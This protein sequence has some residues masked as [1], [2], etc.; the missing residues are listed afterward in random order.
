MSRMEEAY[1]RPQNP[2]IPVMVD[3]E[4]ELPDD[5]PVADDFYEFAAHPLESSHPP[6]PPRGRRSNSHPE[7]P[8]RHGTDPAAASTSANA[9]P[10]EI[11]GTPQRHGGRVPNEPSD[12]RSRNF[13]SFWDLNLLVARPDRY[14][15]QDIGVV[16]TKWQ[17]AFQQAGNGAWD[18]VEY[19][20]AWTDPDWDSRFLYIQG[21]V[22]EDALTVQYAKPGLFQTQ[23]PALLPADAQYGPSDAAKRWGFFPWQAKEQGNDV[24]DGHSGVTPTLTNLPLDTS[25]RME[26]RISVTAQEFQRELLDYEKTAGV[27]ATTQGFRQALM[28]KIHQLS[29]H[30]GNEAQV[31]YAR[32]LLTFMGSARE[33][34]NDYQR[35]LFGGSTTNELVERAAWTLDADASTDLALPLHDLVKRERWATASESGRGTLENR[36]RIVYNV[37]NKQGEY[38][39][40]DETLW[41]AMQPALQLVSKVLSMNH[42]MTWAWADIRKTQPT[43]SALDEM[44]DERDQV[45]DEDKS[46]GIKRKNLFALWPEFSGKEEDLD[47]ISRSFEEMRKFCQLGFDSTRYACEILKRTI[48]WEIDSS[49]RVAVGETGDAAVE[50]LKRSY[51]ASHIE[52]TKDQDPPF[53]IQI[54]ISANFLWPLLVDEY[55]AAEK[56]ATSFLVASTMLHE[57]AHAL[58]FARLQMC[59]PAVPPANVPLWQQLDPSWPQ[60]IL[61]Y[62]NLHKTDIQHWLELHGRRWRTE[63]SAPEK[64]FL[65]HLDEAFVEN[66]PTAEEGFATEWEYWGGILQNPSNNSSD[67]GLWRFL[68]EVYSMLGLKSWASSNAVSNRK[69]LSGVLSM[70]QYTRLYKTA[71]WDHQAMCFGHD[72]IKVTSEAL[73]ALIYAT[74]FRWQQARTHFGAPAAA[75][76]EQA[77][78][79]VKDDSECQLLWRWLYHRTVDGV[80]A[81]AVFG[82]WEAWRSWWEG[83]DRLAWA[84]SAATSTMFETMVT[85][86]DAARARRMSGSLADFYPDVEI[87]GFFTAAGHALRYFNVEAMHAQNLAAIYLRLRESPHKQAVWDLHHEKMQARMDEFYL[88]VIA[89]IIAQLEYFSDNNTPQKQNDLQWLT[90]H[91]GIAPLI[92]TLK[93]NLE[94]KLQIAFTFFKQVRDVFTYAQPQQRQQQH[95]EF[96]HGLASLPSSA[97][98][99]A[100]ERLRRMG[101]AEY[102]RLA[103]DDV[104]KAVADSWAAIIVGEDRLRNPRPGTVEA[105]DNLVLREVVETVAQHADTQRRAMEARFP[106]PPNQGRQTPGTGLVHQPTPPANRYASPQAFEPEEAQLFRRITG[107][108]RVQDPKTGFTHY[109]T[110]QDQPTNVEWWEERASS[111][112][113]APPSA[114]S[115]VTSAASMPA[116]PD[117]RAL[118]EDLES[119]LTWL[120]DQLRA[121][122][123][124]GDS[125]V[126]QGAAAAPRSFGPR[127]ANRS[128][129]IGD[130]E[131][132]LTKRGIVRRKLRDVYAGREQDDAGVPGSVVAPNP[133]FLTQRLEQSYQVYQASFVRAPP[134]PLP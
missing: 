96:I 128:V 23:R 94:A 44:E 41:T 104:R 125:A 3:S 112:Q 90:R 127:A 27:R 46:Y 6:R 28:D 42:P 101:M 38:T 64:G 69:F 82:V 102:A 78:R 124:L 121:E 108:D 119:R 61:D 51:G 1:R 59:A 71:F 95:Q 49:F 107:L 48:Q 75:W 14:P 53:R 13:T 113:L 47:R 26:E 62:N 99:I 40:H 15:T 129:M 132:T 21:A 76:M 83:E 16:R 33:E 92:E 52:R 88:S 30:A 37:S 35:F 56:A 45:S 70:Q 5:W 97:S 91:E 2:R 134:F 10:S 65:Y 9:V 18:F 115:M 19:V 73:P 79:R 22:A 85:A 80:E 110:V 66:Q 67:F 126:A 32:A 93:N 7:R 109:R 100:S 84:T 133:A 98:Q 29:E 54:T 130:T 120:G 118:Q 8:S 55:S 50:G 25:Q 12:P 131:E 87:V 20:P 89:K 74:H 111:R 63:T 106:C 122:E 57:L 72:A 117:L 43:R 68:T 4:S 81:S 103:P 24:P 17:Q 58:C 34:R 60:E 86:I 123:T 39:A 11:S 116:P 36:P 114:A 77:W 105:S 31:D